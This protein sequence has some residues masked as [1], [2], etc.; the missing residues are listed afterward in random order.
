MGLRRV[1]R[2]VDN[3]QAADINQLRSYIEVIWNH[4]HDYVDV[5]GGGG[6]GC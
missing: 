5:V 3:I 1:K 2:D 6:G 4:S